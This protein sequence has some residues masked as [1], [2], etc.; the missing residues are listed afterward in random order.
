VRRETCHLLSR[1]PCC[2]LPFCRRGHARRGG[3]RAGVEQDSASGAGEALG[4]AGRHGA[5]LP[6][7]VLPTGDLGYRGVRGGTRRV[8]IQVHCIRGPCHPPSIAWLGFIKGLLKL[9][10]K[11]LTGCIKPQTMLQAGGVKDAAL[12]AEIAGPTLCAAAQVRVTFW[13][14]ARFREPSS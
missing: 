7:P 6:R 9:K 14:N 1:L 11:V 4:T 5:I 10:A 3:V 12:V 13:A 8:R 2:A